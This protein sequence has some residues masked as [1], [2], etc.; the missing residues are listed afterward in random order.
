MTIW[1]LEKGG[2]WGEVGRRVGYA[3]FKL[4]HSNF[5]IFYSNIKVNGEKINS[6]TNVKR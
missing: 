4:R 1:V 2:G 3:H 6:I 5:L